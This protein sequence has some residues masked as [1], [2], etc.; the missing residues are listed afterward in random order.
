MNLSRLRVLLIDDEKKIIDHLQS[1][2]PWEE[3]GID[4]A[5]SANNGLQAL[6]LVHALKPDMVLCDIRMPV[7]DGLTFLERL[8]EF[9]VDCE[10]I[11]LTGYQDFEYARSAIKLQVRD[12]ILKPINYEE[13]ERAVERLT[14]TIRGRKQVRLLDEQKLDR[15]INLANEKM[16]YD[17]LM[18]YASVSAQYLLDEDASLSVEQRRYI[19]ILADM[20]DYSQKCRTWKEKERK[21]WN[22]ATSN[23]LKEALLPFKLQYAVIQMRE[24]EWCILVEQRQ[25]TVE[26]GT[27]DIHFEKGAKS[28]SAE[29]SSDVIYLWSETLQK[30]VASNEKINLSLGIYLHP[31]TLHE[32]SFIYKKL[33]R[34]VHLIPHKD[35]SII[36]YGEPEEQLEN[37]S[38]SLWAWIE[39]LVSGLK[40]CD[41]AKTE[42]ALQGLSNHL[43]TLSV[44]SLAQV[45][46]ISHFVILHLMREMRGMEVISKDDESKIWSLME[47]SM[48]AKDMLSVVR[49]LVD[50]SLETALNKKPSDVLM[51]TAKDYIHHH[52]SKDLGI[53]ELADHLNISCSYFSLLFKQHFDVTFVEYVTS[54]R[55]ELAKSLLLLTDKS[56]TEIGKS[57]GYWERRYFTKVFHKYTGD[58][59]SEFREKHRH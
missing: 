10:V 20:D 18:D 52:L 45:E 2:I 22:Y 25:E 9:N 15:A 34:A 56:V 3:M 40:Q 7:M 35:S 23:V 28:I 6:N 24:G 46:Q 36:I 12:Y 5:G 59:P 55:M 16:L 11:M 33:Q 26:A 41:R 30:A 51:L 47:Q 17:T 49:H 50:V 53:E 44:R 13:L 14:V 39:S 38:D 29:I 32:L 19:M 48:R 42:L 21:L 1:V 4:I 43:Q 8:R 27:A 37:S 31:V 58:I 57:V 54:H